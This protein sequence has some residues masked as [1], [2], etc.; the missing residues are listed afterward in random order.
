M[1]NVVMVSIISFFGGFEK[2]KNIKILTV[3]RSDA[4][5]ASSS[6]G[7]SVGHK[8]TPSSHLAPCLHLI[9]WH[10]SYDKMKNSVYYT[11]RYI[12]TYIF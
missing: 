8:Q 4:H 5:N 10:R 6:N 2:A 3:V 9:S 11:P 1:K 12:S 7:Q